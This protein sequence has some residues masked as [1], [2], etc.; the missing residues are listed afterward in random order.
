MTKVE[1]LS[2]SAVEIR[3]KNMPKIPKHQ[4]TLPKVLKLPT[5]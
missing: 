3:H 4:I 5:I 1:S 2:F